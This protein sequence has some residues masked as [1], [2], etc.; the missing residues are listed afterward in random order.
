MRVSLGCE[1][2]QFADG[3]LNEEIDVMKEKLS[4]GGWV[5]TGPVSLMA[6]A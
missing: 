2:L 5:V 3:T 1:R 4:R 6:L